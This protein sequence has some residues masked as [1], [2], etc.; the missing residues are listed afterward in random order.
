MNK[1]YLNNNFKLLT[2]THFYLYKCIVKNLCDIKIKMSPNI[3]KI[4]NSE[5]DDIKKIYTNKYKNNDKINTKINNNEEDYIHIYENHENENINTNIKSVDDLKKQ[6][7]L[8]KT[9]KDYIIFYL[10]NNKQLK[11]L[12][13]SIILLFFDYYS[14]FIYKEVIKEN[15]VKIE[16]KIKYVKLNRKNYNDTTLVNDFA[17]SNKDIN[18][19]ILNNKINHKEIDII[20]EDI[21]KFFLSK[22]TD[23][24]F[25][26]ILI[27]SLIES[28]NKIKTSLDIVINEKELLLKIQYLILRTNFLKE[29]PVN[30]YYLLLKVF[31]D[32]FNRE[33]SID[34]EEVFEKIEYEIINFIKNQHSLNT[35]KHKDNK[36]TKITIKNKKK[37]QQYLS[38]IYSYNSLTLNLKEKSSLKISLF[39]KFF[40]SFFKT[41]SNDSIYDFLIDNNDIL[42]EYNLLECYILF[43]KNAEGSHELYNY[44]S[45]LIKPN[46]HVMLNNKYNNIF[47]TENDNYDKLNRDVFIQVYYSSVIALNKVC[48]SKHFLRMIKYL[49]YLIYNEV[50][51]KSNYNN[52]NN[53]NDFKE[54]LAINNVYNSKMLL[55]S[56]NNRKKYDIYNKLI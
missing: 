56:L 43:A 47:Y 30:Y 34:S 8:L 19:F 38:N 46:L 54:W 37:N 55:W 10:K 27:I 28:S 33:S 11:I 21:T 53:N 49:E 13:P 48:N 1:K 2:N 29:I 39:K 35:A 52:N 16:N 5:E 41:N 42:I 31:E 9:R 23:Y 25:D 45:Y 12:N 17:I 50:Y 44:F 22:I 6:L 20:T 3:K 32:Y 24:E 18:E 40:K 14:D 15:N 26:N 36:N 7:L 4:L 51:S